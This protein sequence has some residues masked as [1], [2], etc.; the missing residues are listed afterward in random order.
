MERITPPS[1][2]RSWFNKQTQFVIHAKF[3][4]DE[5][6]FVLKDKENN[7]TIDEFDLC[8]RAMEYAFDMHHDLLKK[9]DEHWNTTVE[10]RE[11]LETHQT[12]L[13]NKL[14]LPSLSPRQKE[15]LGFMLDVT[16]DTI[17]S[18]GFLYGL[19]KR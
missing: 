1:F 9:D 15:V 18:E 5:C 13:I 16:R 12:E 4:K 14:E 3:P 17:A 19:D 10:I 7:I 8:I 2:I 11:F 6:T